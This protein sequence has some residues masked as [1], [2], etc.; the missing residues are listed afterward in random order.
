MHGPCYVG[1]ACWPPSSRDWEPAS[2]QA[3]AVRLLSEERRH[4]RCGQGR[5]FVLCRLLQ[6]ML[7][8][9]VN[10]ACPA[11]H[12]FINFS[13]SAMYHLSQFAGQTLRNAAQQPF[14]LYLGGYMSEHLGSARVHV[15]VHLVLRLASTYHNIVRH[16]GRCWRGAETV[17]A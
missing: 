12:A 13:R 10:S 11:K 14:L 17:R 7:F 1:A 6:P 8:V 2:T 4:K 5:A 3:A 16:T 15:S 9:G